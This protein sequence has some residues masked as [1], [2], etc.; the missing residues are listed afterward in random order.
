MEAGGRR[1]EQ[2]DTFYAFHPGATPNTA[3]RQ[4][5]SRLGPVAIPS[6]EEC[7]DLLF[8]DAN[9]LWRGHS[10]TRQILEI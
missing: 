7:P 5:P 4:S 1:P 3:A 2:A 9:S 6:V 8:Q 10:F